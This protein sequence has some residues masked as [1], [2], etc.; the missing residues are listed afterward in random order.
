MNK[1]VRKYPVD[2]LPADLRPGLPPHGWVRIEIETESDSANSGRLADF[3]GSG[4]NV[5]GTP[6]EAV[7]Y[8]RWLRED[9]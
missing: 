6:D 9:R 7:A 8:I 5:H 2:R 1:I 3:V 4:Q